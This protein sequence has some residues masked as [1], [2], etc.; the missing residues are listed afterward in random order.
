RKRFWKGRAVAILAP[1]PER[2]SGGHADG[3]AGCDWA[4]LPLDRARQW[5]RTLFLETMERIGGLP[6]DRFGELPI[7][8]SPEGYRLRA[9]FHVVGRG[10]AAAL[11]FFA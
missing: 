3:C 7:A 11:G 5:K 8:A 9:R 10:P 2:L 1:S 4:H 6:A